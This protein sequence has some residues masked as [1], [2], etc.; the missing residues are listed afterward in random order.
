MS[1]TR[2]NVHPL[3]CKVRALQGELAEWLYNCDQ[4]NLR[5]A[6]LMEA[7][8]WQ[9]ATRIEAMVNAADGATSLNDTSADAEK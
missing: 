1:P 5:A 2:N 6:A 9:L 4:K 7:D 3:L 8:V